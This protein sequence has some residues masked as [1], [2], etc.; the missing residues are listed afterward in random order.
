MTAFDTTN[1]DGFAMTFA[2]GYTVSVQWH[3]GTYS[4]KGET[5]AEVAIWLGEKWATHEFLPV[6]NEDVSGWMTPEQVVE[7]LATV[8]KSAV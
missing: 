2:N 3:S 1:N 4:D 5:T 6:S 7:L 8:A